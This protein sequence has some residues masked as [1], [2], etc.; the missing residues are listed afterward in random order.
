MKDKEKIA[1]LID[2]L[3]QYQDWRRGIIEEYDMNPTQIGKDLDEAIKLL[4]ELNKQ[5]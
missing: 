2:R 1:D 3:Q 4:Q 5:P